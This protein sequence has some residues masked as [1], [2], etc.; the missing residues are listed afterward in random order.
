MN[1][2]IVTWMAAALMPGAVALAENSPAADR[3]APVASA[4]AE[5]AD[6]LAQR[7]ST[8]LHT[9][10]VVGQPM[11]VG[12]VTLIPIMMIDVGFAGGSM[13]APASTE[14][15][16]PQPTPGDGFLMT[17]E[18]RPLGFVVSSSKGTRFVSV[19]ATP[20]K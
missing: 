7:L 13:P 11:T 10:T 17:G 16:A 4:A 15:G 14:K 9:K 5:L 2:R 12:S 8:N 20:V 3:P 18:A 1:R 6:G 19:A